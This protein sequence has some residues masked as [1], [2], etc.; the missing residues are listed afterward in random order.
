MGNS[1]ATKAMVGSTVIGVKR[2]AEIVR[3]VLVCGADI[4][5]VFSSKIEMFDVFLLLFPLMN[6]LSG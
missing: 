6:W 2:T 4:H 3:L 1:G 5:T